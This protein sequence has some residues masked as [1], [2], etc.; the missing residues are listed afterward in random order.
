MGRAIPGLVLLAAL[1][2]LACTPLGGPT[3]P[4]RF[5]LL[6]PL[7]GPPERTDGPQ[8]GIG[9]VRLASYLDRPQMVTRRGENALDLA[10]FDRWAEPLD[11]SITR[12]LL[13]DLAAV[14]GTDRIQRHPW[15]GPRTVEVQLDLDVQ[16]FDGPA[17]GPVELVASWRLRRGPRWVERVSR[18]A[19]PHEGSGYAAQAAAMSRALARLAREIGQAVP[20]AP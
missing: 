11:E 17:E 4:S 18:I 14:L 8:L 2:G 16:R 9:P 7:E 10:E 20:A 6:R 1:A 3:P 15:R 13:A 19:E 12:V 5:Y